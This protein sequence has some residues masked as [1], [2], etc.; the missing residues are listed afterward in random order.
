MQ[1]VHRKI[2]KTNGRTDWTSPTLKL[3]LQN[4]DYTGML[5]AKKRLAKT[6]F[7]KNNK[8]TKVNEINISLRSS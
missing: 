3:M 2:S 5:F 4:S 1:T 8:S 7:R 6:T